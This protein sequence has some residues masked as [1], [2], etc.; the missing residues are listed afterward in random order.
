MAT[1]FLAFYPVLNP[2]FEHSFWTQGRRK[3][4]SSGEG[5]STPPLALVLSPNICALYLWQ[6]LSSYNDTIRCAFQ[7]LPHSVIEF[8]GCSIQW[9]INLTSIQ[10]TSVDQRKV[11]A[12][13]IKFVTGKSRVKCANR[14]SKSEKSVVVCICM[15]R[16]VKAG[17]LTLAG[18]MMFSRKLQIGYYTIRWLSHIRTGTT[19]LSYFILFSH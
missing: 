18:R 13:K 2:S 14:V 4:V 11:L 1:H 3:V 19:N 15:F 8:R 16:G 17:R 12:L 10:P 7:D 5:K 9:P 6:M